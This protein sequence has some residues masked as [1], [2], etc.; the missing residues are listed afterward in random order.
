VV[1]FELFLFFAVYFA[2]HIFYS[3]HTHTIALVGGD[4]PRVW[5]TALIS[6]C[7][8]SVWDCF[9]ITGEIESEKEGERQ[10]ETD[11]K[12]FVHFFGI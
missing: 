9:F 6:I 11:C 4:W 1:F 8:K 2:V 10:T 5:H 12:G 3:P 7:H